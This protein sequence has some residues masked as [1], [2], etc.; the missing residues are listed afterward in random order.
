MS[1][2]QRNTT[3]KD[4]KNETDKRNDNVKEKKDGSFSTYQTL[5]IDYPILMN[6]IQSVIISTCSVLVSQYIAGNSIIDW[7][8]IYTVQ[9]VAACW[10]TPVLLVFYKQLQKMSFGVIGKLLID[11][12][13]FSPIFTASIVTIRLLNFSQMFLY[14][15]S[16]SITYV[17]YFF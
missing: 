4:T 5:M 3:T 14:F 13:L 15:S 17:C 10:I 12:A 16:F 6:I 1:T 2:S 11:Q 8:E 7:G 9:I